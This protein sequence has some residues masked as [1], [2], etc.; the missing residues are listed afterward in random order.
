[1]AQSTACRAEPGRQLEL[2]GGQPPLKPRMPAPPAHNHTPTSLAAA[3]SIADLAPGLRGRVFEA[4]RQA[5]STGLTRHE[6]AA[7][8]GIALPSVCP[9]VAELLKLGLIVERGTRP[10]PS[11]RAAAILI[12]T[13]RTAPRDEP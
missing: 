5:A 12:E 11:G 7:A 9:R 2:F 3:E 6:I 10:S 1:M 13:E 8:T 4:I